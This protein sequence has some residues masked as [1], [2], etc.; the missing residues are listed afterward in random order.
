MQQ[1]AT[2]EPDGGSIPT[3][4][5]GIGRRKQLYF[6]EQSKYV[7]DTSNMALSTNLSLTPPSPPPSLEPVYLVYTAEKNRG[8]TLRLHFMLVA[9]WAVGALKTVSQALYAYK[10]TY[11]VVLPQ[12]AFL[13]V[14]QLLNLYFQ[15]TSMRVLKSVA[16]QDQVQQEKTKAWLLTL[17]D[18]AVMVCV[19]LSDPTLP[20]SPVPLS[21]MIVT[22]FLAVL[23][24]LRL[25][26]LLELHVVKWLC[27]AFLEAD[28][29]MRAPG[30]TAAK[31]GRDV[32][33]AAA[34]GTALPLALAAVAEVY[35]REAFLRDC[36]KP[37][38]EL[39]P[40]WG[41]LLGALRRVPGMGPSVPPQDPHM[42]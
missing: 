8:L 18:V 32:A 34:F 2:A 20:H 39:N 7:V 42:E 12:Y 30:M 3:R 21:T 16:R 17:L 22:S 1:D 27:F 31:L 33:H 29:F 13:L 40:F 26:T 38:S 6:S 19:I 4:D 35:Q 11:N 9:A 28:H 37:M 14:V 25:G 24:M 36:R 10:Q 5:S 23:D 15:A 41:G